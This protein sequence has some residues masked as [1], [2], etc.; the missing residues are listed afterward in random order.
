[1]KKTATLLLALG[2]SM[3]AF[4]QQTPN[5]V[6]T[7]NGETNDATIGEGRIYPGGSPGQIRFLKEKISYKVDKQEGR[8]FSGAATIKGNSITFVGSLS[9]D[10]SSGAIATKQ[11]TTSFKMVD[12]NKIALCFT[13]TTIDPANKNAGPVADCHEISRK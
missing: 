7:W 9:G 5:L 3:S 4:A 11:G 13:T 12:P 2:F 10:L 6:G 1:M 8:T